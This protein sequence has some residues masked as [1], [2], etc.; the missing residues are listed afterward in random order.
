[1]IYKQKA[2][3]C[4]YV[5]TRTPNPLEFRRRRSLDDV[6]AS[7]RLRRTLASE[8]FTSGSRRPAISSSMLKFPNM[9]NTLYD[10]RISKVMV[11]C[12]NTCTS[13]CDFQS[14]GKILL[15]ARM[16]RVLACPTRMPVFPH[17]MSML[18]TDP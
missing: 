6:Q 1:M 13:I 11:V 15:P 9:Q 5:F 18:C 4:T 2:L 17:V 16:Q 14:Y 8:N 7:S 10:F 12:I 3:F